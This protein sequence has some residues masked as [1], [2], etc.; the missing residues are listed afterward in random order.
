MTR[1]SRVFIKSRPLRSV[2][3]FTD[4]EIALLREESDIKATDFSTPIS[5]DFSTTRLDGL[6]HIA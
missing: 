4:A 2:A 1:K 5:R 3:D 6:V